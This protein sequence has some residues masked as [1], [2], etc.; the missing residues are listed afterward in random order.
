ME[1][2]KTS[3]L[4]GVV[5]RVPAHLRRLQ[6]ST[7]IEVGAITL[8][9]ILGS[10]HIFRYGLG[11]DDVSYATPAQQVTLE[12]W[13][14]GRLPLWSD[15]T[16]GGTP[17][18]GN[19]QTAAIYPGHLLSAPFPDLVGPHV[20][21]SLHLLLL[22]VGFY[23]L[24]RRLRLARPAPTVMAIGAMLSGA[25][26]IRA[27][28]LVHFPPLAWVPLAAACIHAV[29]VSN[30]P[31][32]AS[33]ALAF[34]IWCILVAGHPQSVL[35]AFT[36]LG[37]WAVGL[38]IEHRAWR[39]AAWMAGSGALS[40]AMAAPVLF[41][42][43]HSMSV[44]AA[45][46]RDVSA[47]L[48]PGSFVPL[49]AFPR[50]ILGEPL[51]ALSVLHMQGEQRTYAGVAIVALSL[52]GTL[53]V[54]R[55]RR[56]SLVAVAL[57]GAFAATLSFGAR[58]PTL[59]FARA[60]LPGFDQPR[61]SARW[62]WVLVMAMVILAGAGVDRL[63]KGTFRSGGLALAAI[64]IF[65]ATSMFIGVEEA[66]AGNT[67]LWIVGAGLVVAIA[68]IAHHRYRVLATCLLA[69]LAVF[70][71][72]MPIIKLI[73]E[74]NSDIT[75]TS[76]LIGPTERFLA[77]QSGL[78][79]SF[80]TGDM[81]G[82]YVVAGLRP[83]ANTLAGVRMLDGY[84]GGVAISRRWHAALLQI[85]PAYND[86]VF[87]AQL[88]AILDPAA[89]ARLGIRFV[90]YD[91]ARGPATAALPGWVQR[92]AS[93][94]F[95]L[96]ENPFWHGDVTAWYTTE[97]VSGPEAAGNTLRTHTG[98]YHDVGL[99]EAADAVLTCTGVCA[100]TYFNSNSNQSGERD[101]DVQLDHRAAV[102]FNEQFDDGWTV[103][104]DGHEADVIAVDGVWVGVVVPAGDHRVELRYAP[105]W[106]LP[107]LVL[108]AL[109]W[110]GL[111]GLWF[112]PLGLRR[113][114]VDAL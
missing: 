32:Q 17:H 103:T 66:G 31:R 113:R 90:L 75:S 104:V 39:R 106:V 30:R 72:G 82:H 96:F 3:T 102:A 12:A 91:P 54:A 78:T 42:L 61:V 35:M 22:G 6:R 101:A 111:A 94:F 55:A 70:E 73:D 64:G 48:T 28:L 56:W 57:V 24:G 34:S 36:L 16:F 86:L 69:V 67:A 19:I 92:E 23:L 37:A 8:A 81:E 62:N 41:A 1:P 43:R 71:L 84:D 107:S 10:V 7:A 93:G 52:V 110:L 83:N 77:E 20:Q 63:R 15:T 47:L 58:S 109:A 99:V 11:F 29:V 53:A 74:G 97:S 105:S 13:R 44:A 76:Q 2:A 87:G 68:V 114:I 4:A 65:A 50:L 45:S 79:Q 33:V 112:W 80:I 40:L 25:T 14:H 5:D 100:P 85:N 51:S 60:F 26:M 59:R 21:L 88:P 95:Q 18:L 9:W 38:V 98:K 49:R 27:P 46:T 108:M 89:F